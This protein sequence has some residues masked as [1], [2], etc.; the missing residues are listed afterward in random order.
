MYQKI[1][2]IAIY[3]PQFH[4]TPENDE[5]W[6]KGFTEWTNVTKAK[7]LFTGHEQPN[8]PG[9]LGFYDLRVPE[10]REQQAEL[11]KE[12]GIEGFMYWHYWFD[13]RRILERPFNEVLAS[14]K[15]DFPFCL[16][17]ANESWKTIWHGHLKKGTFLEQTYPGE[18]DYKK[19]FYAVLP[20]F[21]DKRYITV[22]KKCFFLIYKPFDI[23]N[24]D[25][26][27]TTWRNLAQENGLNGIYFVALSN[28]A[29][30]EYDKLIKLGFDAIQSYWL[31]SLLSS[32]HKR[33]KTFR[34]RLNTKLR[35]IMHKPKP[36]SL[37]KIY[38]YKELI[39][40]LSAPID[41]TENVFPTLLP[42][43]DTSP[44]L[45]ENGHIVVDSSPELFRKHVKNALKM[46]EQKPEEQRILFIKS[47]NEW[48]EGNYIEPDRKF[49]RQYL[50]VLRDEIQH[51]NR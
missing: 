50:E 1:R 26:L 22:N 9:E 34:E 17:W 48:A 31:P 47:W 21:K 19:H 35:K 3:L 44:R 6:G 30:K 14:G 51:F 4:P 5:W 11:A 28:Y 10:V 42:N 7:P 39:P 13:G 18:E 23:P 41:S 12:H 45:A 37:L 20:A 38:K 49:G 33:P 25:L 27:L 15:P 24:I 8:L 32:S 46:L 43:W 29:D 2:P 16:G 36:Q 40:Y